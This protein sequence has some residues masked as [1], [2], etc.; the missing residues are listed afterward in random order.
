MA[1]STSQPA[2]TPTTT[3]TTIRSAVMIRSRSSRATRRRAIGGGQGRLQMRAATGDELLG[4]IEQFQARDH[5]H[6]WIGKL[7]TI[8]SSWTSCR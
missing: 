8:G 6:Q 5:H 3:T 7:V 1:T 4:S 2:S